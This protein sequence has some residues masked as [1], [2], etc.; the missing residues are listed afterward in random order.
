MSALCFVPG[1]VPLADGRFRFRCESQRGH[2]D[3]GR[4]AGEP[5]QVPGV[6]QGAA[7]VVLPAGER[8]LDVNV[9]DLASVAVAGPEYDV[10]VLEA[11]QVLRVMPVVSLLAVRS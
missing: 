4:L 3:M 6:A 7:G 1:D 2:H 10:G 8:R 5:R 11:L 9:V